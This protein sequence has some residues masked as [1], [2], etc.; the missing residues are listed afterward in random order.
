MTRPTFGL[1]VVFSALSGVG[2]LLWTLGVRNALGVDVA[3]SVYV[4]GVIPLFLLWAAPSWGRGAAAAG[5]AAALGLPTAVWWPTPLAAASTAVFALGVARLGLLQRP[6]G[7]RS[8]GAEALQAAAALVAA[9]Y[10]YD[11]TALGGAAAVWVASLVEF[12]GAARDAGLERAPTARR[13]PF[14][15]AR[16]QVLHILEAEE[17]RGSQGH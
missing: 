2:A 5:L 17:N 14:E 7:L 4:L 12:A 13:S 11:G 16:Q 15:V 8:V 9:A 10:A 6:L 1:A 3:V